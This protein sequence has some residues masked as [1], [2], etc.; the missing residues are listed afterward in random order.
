MKKMMVVIILLSCL[1]LFSQTAP[2]FKPRESVLFVSENCTFSTIIPAVPPS[3]IQITVQSLPEHVSFVSS[4]KQEIFLD[5]VKGTELFI[6][7]KFARKGNYTVSPV[8]ARIQYGFEHISF[9]KVTVYDN[10][11]TIQPRLLLQFE[12]DSGNIINGGIVGVPVKAVLYGMYFASVNTVRTGSFETGILIQKKELQSLPHAENEFTPSSTALIAFEYTPFT[13]GIHIIEGVSAEVTSWAGI[14]SVI[15]A[16][17]L[18]LTVRA[19]TGERSETFMP[20]GL[21]EAGKTLF[22]HAFDQTAESVIVSQSSPDDEAALYESYLRKR[23]LLA[24]SAYITVFLCITGMIFLAV[25]RIFKKQRRFLWIAVPLLCIAAVLQVILLAPCYG[26]YTGGSVY[27]IPETTSKASF[28][29]PE[30]T[31]VRVHLETLGWTYISF[32]PVRNQPVRKGGWVRSDT[33]AI[34]TLKK[35]DN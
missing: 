12:D 27:T 14:T 8:A 35:R 9:Q 25:L 10:P 34:I 22:P 16:E 2:P 33:V 5:G 1:P 20:D 30:S 13:E 11:K 17:A 24:F 21:S 15:S 29:V 6:V 4:K 7:L 19:N 23:T 31:L 3:Q 28:T 18:S 32:S 26:I